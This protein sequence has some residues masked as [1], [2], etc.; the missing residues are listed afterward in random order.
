MRDSIGLF[1]GLWVT[2]EEKE[3][4]SSNANLLFDPEQHRMSGE[5]SFDISFIWFLPNER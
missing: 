1:Y 5:L 2:L 3:F 4:P